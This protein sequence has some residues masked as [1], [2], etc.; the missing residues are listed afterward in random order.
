MDLKNLPMSTAADKRRLVS[1][2]ANLLQLFCL[3]DEQRLVLVRSDEPALE[4]ARKSSLIS[5]IVQQQPPGFLGSRGNNRVFISGYVHIPAV[6]FIIDCIHQQVLG[7]PSL[8]ELKFGLRDV[9]NPRTLDAMTGLHATLW[10]LGIDRYFIHTDIY[11]WLLQYTKRP[12][13]LPDFKMTAYRCH[14]DGELIQ[15]MME[16]QAHWG[17]QY[18]HPDIAAIADWCLAAGLVDQLHKTG[19]ETGA[20]MAMNRAE[21]AETAKE[22]QGRRHGGQEAKTKR[23]EEREKRFGLSRGRL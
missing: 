18:N 9:N 3:D 1:K 14:L 4:I 17:L 15:H 22:R 2:N 12:L 5:G 21:R 10:A 7:R 23:K 20:E 6:N 8:G 19:L 16:N 13:S 11:W